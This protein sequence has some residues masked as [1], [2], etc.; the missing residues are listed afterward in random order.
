MKQFAVIGLGRFGEGV[1][2]TL[3]RL[4]C[5]VLAIDDDPEKVQHMANI[6]THA[7]QA[8][9]TD[10]DA[11]K[12]LGIRNVDVAVVSIG[13]DIESSILA[14][15]ILKDLGIKFVVAKAHDELHGKVLE[16]V[17]ADRVIYPERD[18]AIRVATS[19]VSGN[20]LDYIE[21]SPEF[22]IAEIISPPEF[23]GKSLRELNIRAQF[24]INVVAIRSQGR[25]KVSPGAD[26]K[27]NEGD[28]LVLIGRTESFEKLP[29]N[30]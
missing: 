6:V 30:D 12:S 17:G 3:S 19:L 26:D 18:M 20:I 7:V 23:V 25:I 28:I 15:L 9:A 24:G 27:I 14:T 2:R 22:T 10:E 21:L 11:L 16:R 4:G 8:N 13:E 5:Q 1:A 29:K